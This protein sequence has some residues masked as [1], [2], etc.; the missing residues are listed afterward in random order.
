MN[1]NFLR[2]E[3]T[4][5]GPQRITVKSSKVNWNFSRYCPLITK[6]YESLELEIR[7]KNPVKEIKVVLS[8]VVIATT[9]KLVN[10]VNRG[11][12]KVDFFHELSKHMKLTK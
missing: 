1:F 12:I 3:T 8:F 2:Y 9:A 10:S 4:K 11:S 7:H 6:Y 5:S